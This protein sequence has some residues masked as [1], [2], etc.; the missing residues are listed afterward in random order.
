MIIR[1]IRIIGYICEEKEDQKGTYYI[2]FFMDEKIFC[3]GFSKTG[4]TSLESALKL[5]GYNV[6]AGDY[7]NNYS[8]YLQGLYVN[9]DFEEILKITH[10]FDA[11]ADAPWA[12]GRLHPMLE[13]KYPNAKFILTTRDSEKWFNSLQKMLCKFATGPA[14]AFETFHKEG[15]YGI[16]RFLSKVFDIDTLANNKEKII[17]GYEQYNE[18]MLAYFAGREDFLH[19]DLTVDGNWEELCA[20]LN[21]PIPQADFPHQNKAPNN[22]AEA[23]T[24]PKVGV[25]TK[26]K[27]KMISII[28]KL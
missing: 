24:T 28:K 12:G 4:T 10:Y 21:K 25:K 2:L 11:F 20:F 19:F 9:N 6:C 18:E 3:I 22:T 13:Q 14:D 5:L 27:N 7:R 26:V 8:N 16:V 23:L 17:A 15:R 1:F